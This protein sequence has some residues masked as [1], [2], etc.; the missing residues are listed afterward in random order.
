MAEKNETKHP[1]YGSAKINSVGA[2]KAVRSLT[3]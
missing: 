2:T 3:V 1:K